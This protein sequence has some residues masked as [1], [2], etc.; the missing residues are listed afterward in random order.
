MTKNEFSAKDA[1]EDLK[2]RHKNLNEKR[3]QTETNLINAKKELENLK[4]NAREEYG[5]D[6]LDDLKNKLT[7][8]K[9]ENEKK[10]RDYKEHLD[11]IEKNLEEINTKH[12]S[13][14]E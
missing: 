14:G 7:E 10:C 13:K 6:N 2:K 3:I 4:E 12:S 11:E 1:I 9:E 5:T 8:M